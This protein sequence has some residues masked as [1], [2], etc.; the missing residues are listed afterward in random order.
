MSARLSDE[1][2]VPDTVKSPVMETLP[3]MVTEPDESIVSL[4]TPP[5]TNAI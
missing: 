4:A 1:V 2:N 3:G 5:V